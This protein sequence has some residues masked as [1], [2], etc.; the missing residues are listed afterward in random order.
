MQL[1]PKKGFP[2]RAIRIAQAPNK[3]L[4]APSIV[5]RNSRK[6]DNRVHCLHPRMKLIK[7]LFI[8]INPSHSFTLSF[9]LDASNCTAKK[10]PVLF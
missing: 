8:N 6:H 2:E 5:N 10:Y 7:C 3:D 4:I 9:Q 1:K